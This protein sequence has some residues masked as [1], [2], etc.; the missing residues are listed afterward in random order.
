LYFVCFWTES[1]FG[2]EEVCVQELTK[3]NKIE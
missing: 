3:S 1:S 2:G